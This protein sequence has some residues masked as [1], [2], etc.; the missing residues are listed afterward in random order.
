MLVAFS[1]KIGCEIEATWAELGEM[2]YLT[3]AGEEKSLA[4][5][6]WDDLLGFGFICKCP[7]ED[8]ED[9]ETSVSLILILDCDH[10][11]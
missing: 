3:I 4:I 9:L 6:A 1:S 2:L 7:G 5:A 10:Q 8:A 11:S